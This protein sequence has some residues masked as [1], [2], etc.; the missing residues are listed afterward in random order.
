MREQ[1]DVFDDRPLT[2]ERLA[3]LRENAY[4]ML[5]ELEADGQS[6]ENSGKNETS[7]DES[8]YKTPRLGRVAHGA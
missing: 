6:A 3:E 5:R 4:E 2:L 7:A 8:A 1:V